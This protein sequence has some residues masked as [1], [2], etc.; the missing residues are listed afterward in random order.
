MWDFNRSYPVVYVRFICVIPVDFRETGHERYPN[1]VI[2]ECPVKL[3]PVPNCDS[4]G[5]PLSE[6]GKTEDSEVVKHHT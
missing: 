4:S 1:T 6:S 3:N 2:R 5:K